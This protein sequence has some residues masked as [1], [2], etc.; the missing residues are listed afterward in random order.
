MEGVKEN[1]GQC[2]NGALDSVTPRSQSQDV[3][4]PHSDSSSPSTGYQHGVSI[5]RELLESDTCHPRIS[6]NRM[7]DLGTSDPNTVRPPNML[8]SST[9]NSSQELPISSALIERY[10]ESQQ[11]VSPQKIHQ[12]GEYECDLTP[13][14]KDSSAMVDSLAC[15]TPLDKVPSSCAVPVLRPNLLR[16]FSSG[17]LDNTSKAATAGSETPHTLDTDFVSSMC[18]DSQLRHITLSCSEHDQGS[19]A[20]SQST[21]TDKKNQT[22]FSG[23]K[24]LS[25][26]QDSFFPCQA[27]HSM[28]TAQPTKARTSSLGCHN[29]ELR[30]CQPSNIL[31]KHGDAIQKLLDQKQIIL[32]KALARIETSRLPKKAMAAVVGPYGSHRIDIDIYLLSPCDIEE[33]VDLIAAELHTPRENAYPT[34]NNYSPVQGVT[35]QTI[36]E[37][38]PTFDGLNNTIIPRSVTV[39]EPAT[40]ISTPQTSF[41]TMSPMDMQ[42][43]T[44]VKG[45]KLSMTSTV[46]S[47]RSVAEIT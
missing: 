8:E 38:L 20:S 37:L 28:P 29:N 2:L 3:L 15:T 22:A 4:C 34:T 27:S 47:K 9:S 31:P 7:Q 1:Q 40:T 26:G 44:K 10:L 13:A 14:Q 16:E 42:V 35:D 36:S 11:R 43:H 21:P 24:P 19:V 33:M 45:R 25:R 41:A 12:L 17:L 46:V 5:P 32:Q 23:D 18:D 39:A 6:N 30:G